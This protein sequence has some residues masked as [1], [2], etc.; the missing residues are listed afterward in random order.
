VCIEYALSPDSSIV[1]VLDRLVSDYY[2]A[3]EWHYW[4]DRILIRPDIAAAINKEIASKSYSSYPPSSL[5]GAQDVRFE[6]PAGSV[7][8][9][10][11]SD[12]DWPIFMGTEEELKDN[13]F[14]I[15]L[16]K[17]LCE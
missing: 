15:Y 11:R 10:V 7:T 17:A 14:N 5:L 12:L 4:N 8:I 13:S 6:T 3:R 1:N 9:I 2:K 16:E